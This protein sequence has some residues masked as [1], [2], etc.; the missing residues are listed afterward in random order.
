VYVKTLHF[1]FG[2]KIK[3]VDVTFSD[4]K[5]QVISGKIMPASE[6][7]LLVSGDS[8]D[9]DQIIE[10]SSVYSS[11][12][13]YPDKWY[14]YNIGCGLDKTEH[15]IILTIRCYPIRYSPAKIL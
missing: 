11:S 6:P 7:V 12:D 2:T 15:V 1:P 3:Y 13:L 9:N 14:D 8:Y 4:I 10:D 5:Q